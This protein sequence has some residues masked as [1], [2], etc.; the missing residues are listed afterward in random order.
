MTF[1]TSIVEVLLAFEEF[2][3]LIAK[4]Q[5]DSYQDST[6]I[7]PRQKNLTFDLLAS[8]FITVKIRLTCEYT[9]ISRRVTQTRK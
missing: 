2:S 3:F 1:W 8:D 7:L 5:I 9:Y 6:F 4:R